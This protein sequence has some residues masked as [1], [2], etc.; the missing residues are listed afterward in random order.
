[1]NKPSGRGRR[2]GSPDTQE[3]IKQAARAR[4]LAEG[5]QAVTLR[6]IAADAGVDV[7][8]VSY[9]FGSKQGLF[10]ATMALPVNPAE[11]FVAELAGDLDTLGERVLRT[12]LTVWDDPGLGTPLR[13]VAA[14]AVSDP[15]LARLVREAVGRE[16]NERLA[17]RLGE[18]NGLHRA[19]AFTTQIAGVILARYLLRIEPIASMS[20]DEVVRGLAPSLQLALQPAG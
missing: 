16:I 5:Y 3:Q 20:I 4:F 8:L 10:G 12:M 14:S 9:Y 7:A 15:G 1:M 2:V 19:A 13:T 6:S 18:P 11:V 17:E